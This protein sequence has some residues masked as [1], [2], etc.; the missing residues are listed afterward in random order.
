MTL[1]GL[2][3]LAPANTNRWYLFH[4][5]KYLVF[6]LFLDY[7]FDGRKNQCAEIHL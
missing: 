2:Q 4:P 7:A 1:Q 6:E 5:F 3:A